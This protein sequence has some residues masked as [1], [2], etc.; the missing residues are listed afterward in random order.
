MAISGRMT[1]VSG[2]ILIGLGITG[3]FLSII[4]GDADVYLILILPVLIFR[5]ILPVISIFLLM[6]GTFIL[7]ITR[8]RSQFEDHGKGMK[9]S[10]DGGGIIFIGPIPIVFGSENVKERC[11]HYRILILIGIVIFIILVAVSLISTL[12]I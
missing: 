2:I 3:I 11:P 10:I 9:G 4:S 8:A 6:A 1:L 5:G 7:I 12:I